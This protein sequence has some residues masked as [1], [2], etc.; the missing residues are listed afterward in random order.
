MTL[1][2]S[3][4][5]L[6]IT[7]GPNEIESIVMAITYQG[8]MI[9]LDDIRQFIQ[10]HVLKTTKQ[11]LDH[12]DPV[13]RDH[14]RAR[15]DALKKWLKIVT[16]LAWDSE[17]ESSGN[18]QLLSLILCHDTNTDNPAL[19][20][21]KDAVTYERL[22]DHLIVFTTR[23]NQRRPAPLT[24]NGG[25]QHVLPIAYRMVNKLVPPGNDRII[26][27]TRHLISMMKK[28]KIHLIPW[29]KVTPNAY[30][31]DINIWV[32]LRQTKGLPA[33]RT[34]TIQDQIREEADRVAQDKPDA[35]WDV[36]ERL[37][38]M[39]RL[40]SKQGLPICWSVEHASLSKS[41]NA[42]YV[43]S[44]YRYVEQEY[45]GKN[46]R[47]HLALVVAILFSRVLP[48]ICSMNTQIS[49]KDEA[50]VTAEIRAMDW[51]P[52]QSAFHKGTVAP[53]PFIVMMSTALIGFWDS[54]SPL[55]A[56][57]VASH[58]VLGKPWTDKHG[59]SIVYSSIFTPISHSFHEGSKQIHA[60]NFIRM[61][62]AIGKTA[63]VCKNAKFKSNW[64]FKSDSD[65]KS[66]Y[67]K[68]IGWLTEH[69][70]GEYLAVH[71]LFGEKIAYRLSKENQYKSQ[72]L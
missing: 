31:T 47:H 21:A 58:Y 3:R 7:T 64:H 6:A 19:Q 16:P 9:F 25:F 42:D 49:S 10:T 72:G 12:Q 59:M 32:S 55:S 33:S 50:G 30:A 4:P 56:H 48:D 40:W 18:Y 61:G 37:C 5:K 54:G 52:A 71:F 53:L 14:A 43:S 20:L 65:L 39:K 2:V 36:P 29:H 68:L 15:R 44:T 46:W 27:W 17:N 8:L 1:A 22:V 63:G 26:Y 62:L 57:L 69:R 28:L 41:N 35:P 66:I 60:L 67:T 11:F 70:F 51:I 13:L 45:D 23:E 24:N 38:D 34:R